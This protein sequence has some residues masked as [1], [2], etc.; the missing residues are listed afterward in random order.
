MRIASC[1]RCD[2][3]R[4]DEDRYD[5]DRYD[6]DRYDDA[7]HILQGSSYVLGRA[8]RVWGSFCVSTP[9]SSAFD[10]VE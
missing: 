1:D 2:D 4:Y 5:E 10:F 3:D 6:D 9:S 7:Y 8:L